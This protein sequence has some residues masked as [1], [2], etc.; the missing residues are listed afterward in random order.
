MDSIMRT[1]EN[2][3]EKW[4]NSDGE[5]HRSILPAVIQPGFQAYYA[6]GEAHR[7]GGPAKIWEDG[8]VE[9][10]VNGR[11]HR[12]DGPAVE[13]HTANTIWWCIY[14][15]R[16]Y[17]FKDFQA[18]GGLSDDEMCILRLKYGEI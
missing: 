4:Y 10:F 8:D 9:W 11:L 18:A 17:N 7:I 5:L 2:G 14:G 12:I 16:Y 1:D 6:N 3:F 15:K 13:C